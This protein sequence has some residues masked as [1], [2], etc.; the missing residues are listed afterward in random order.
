MAFKSRPIAVQNHAKRRTVVWL[1][2]VL[3]GVFWILL[4][5]ESPLAAETSAKAPSN[6]DDAQMA[7][8][9]ASAIFA[10]GCFWCIEADFEKLDAVISAVSGYSGGF[11]E[12]PSYRDVTNGGTGHLEVVK[13]YYDPNKVSYRQLVDFFLRHVDPLDDGGQFCDRGPSYKTAIFAQ[14]ADERA[15][16]LAAVDEAQN[17]LGQKVVTPVR[18][19][20]KFWRAEAYHQDYYKKNALKYKLYRRGCGRDRR[21]RKLWGNQAST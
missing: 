14:T 9:Y 19:R 6:Q 11:T 8:R 15:A 1:S 16:A 2:A 17:V 5:S 18:D 20:V 13:V 10:G 12:N 21:V 4:S 3:F 7:E